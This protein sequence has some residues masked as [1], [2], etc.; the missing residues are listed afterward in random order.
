M[1]QVSGTVERITFQNDENGFTIAKLQVPG[2]HELTTTVG[3]MPAA[4]PGAFLR[5]Y[6]SWK[7][8]LVHGR[9]FEVERYSVESPSDI[10]G[11]KKYLGSG[12][13][14]G[15]G[16]VFAKK[17]VDHFGLD[18]LQVIDESP[19]RLFEIKGVGKK[20]VSQIASCW[21]GQKTIRNVM[22]FLQSHSVSPAYAQ[23]IYKAY[24]QE[25]IK[26]V[27]ENPF[28]LA[29]DIFGIGFKT[30]DT[31][32]CKMGVIKEAVQRIEA[33]IEYA[34]SELSN[35]G[36]VCYPTD[37]FLAFAEKLLE[38]PS[39]MIKQRIDHL[40]QEMRI[41]LFDIVFDGDLRKFI[42][43]KPLFL[44]EVGIA[45]EI[46]RLKNAPCALRPVDVEKAIAWAQEKLAIQLAEQQK[47]AVALSLT[48]K[49]QIITGGPGTG[50]STIT[51]AILRV[52]EKLSGK[53]ILAAPT[54]RAAKRMSEITGKKAKTIHSLLEFDF[55]NG[56][57]KH[58]KENPLD[59]DL[60]IIDEASMID[61]LLMNSLLKAIPSHARAI[62]VGDV[63]QLPSV[64]PGN[65]LKEMIA[66]SQISVTILTEIF[67]QASGSRI[68]T[69]AHR[70]NQGYFPDTR[71]LP[72][73][74]FFFI[75]AK[76]TDQV[77]KEIVTLVIQR[78]PQKYGFHPIQEIQVLAP[79]KRGLIGTENLNAV[80]QQELNSSDNPLMRYGRRFHV[81]DK[82][83]QIRNNYQK[84]IFNGDV[85][86]VKEIDLI[87]Q[88]MVVAFDDRDL[89]YE[90]SELDELV[91]AYAVSI[92]KS[93]G[94]EYPCCI[95][96]VH[97]S[98]FKLLHR[99][100]VY[101]GVTRGKKLV[102][103]VGTK[104]ALAMAVKNDEV[105]KRYSGLKQA[106]LGTL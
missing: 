7:N 23:K 85:G 20:R 56:G 84:E 106:L 102:V 17:I 49:I 64:G 99:N 96:P 14:P 21:E 77:L 82:V 34:L 38:V 91:L 57:F 60:I 13:I 69:N 48:E 6:G 62:L 27:Q 35:E 16:P 22:V 88:H 95:I 100:L 40:K 71:F 50:K 70:I 76:E 24:G 15:I 10:V 86:I 104:Q 5:C 8:H 87:E 46:K 33:G 42:W 65:V 83:M 32:A 25:S 101:T 72:E 78:L 36:H 4:A 12:L 47:K 28:Q 94:S 11:I 61:T 68:I 97:T 9:Q 44:A 43:L 58:K 75:E 81:K 1:E 66:S 74:D 59:C 30:A 51:N 67:R 63:N 55:K 31:I 73:S 26:K 92:H 98:H 18:T 37:E 80:L 93:Q 45:R 19:D 89:V 29:R 41:E 79:M 2:H 39:E 53:I 90:F 105:K 52:S 3:Y 103:L 54:G